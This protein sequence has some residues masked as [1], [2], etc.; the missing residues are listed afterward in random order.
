MDQFQLILAPVV[1]MIFG[2]IV[3][4]LI[5]KFAGDWLPL[6]FYKGR[7]VQILEEVQKVYSPKFDKLVLKIDQNKTD[8]TKAWNEIRNTGE[9]INALEKAHGEKLTRLETLREEDKSLIREVKESVKRMEEKI[10]NRIS[11]LEDKLIE[12]QKEILQSIQASS[13][14]D[15]GKN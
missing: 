15:H 8:I 7:L 3:L 14:R 5:K 9:E 11:R 6:L 4:V 2:V 10:D 12:S 13:L 1:W